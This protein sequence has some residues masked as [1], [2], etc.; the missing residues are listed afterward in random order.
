MNNKNNDKSVITKAIIT[1]IEIIKL[2]VITIMIITVIMIINNSN[3]YKILWK[4]CKV[5]NREM[6]Y[7]MRKKNQKKN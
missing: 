3:L 6:Q 5:G 4:W 1:Q 2:L 7:G